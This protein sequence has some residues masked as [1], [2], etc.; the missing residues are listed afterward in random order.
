MDGAEGQR[1][2]VIANDH[3]EIFIEVELEKCVAH[4]ILH[5]DSKNGTS[6]FMELEDNVRWLCQRFEGEGIGTSGV[7]LNSWDE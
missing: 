6:V 7:L 5:A 4:E 2:A 3:V 1:T